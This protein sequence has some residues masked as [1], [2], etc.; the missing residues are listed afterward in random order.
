[1]ND[2]AQKQP[3]PTDNPINAIGT[4]FLTPQAREQLV[5]S[6]RSNFESL[7]AGH[8]HDLNWQRRYFTNIYVEALSA[9]FSTLDDATTQL[10]AASTAAA[11]QREQVYALITAERT[12]QDAKWGSN[13][14][15]HPYLWLTILTEE[16]G[17]VARAALGNDPDNLRDELVQV[18]AVAIAQLEAMK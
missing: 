1:M 2:T 4:K 15:L 14:D 13:R 18:A 6:L 10:H 8:E 9:V 3:E 5:T 12:R 7:I 11:T 16:V 17:E